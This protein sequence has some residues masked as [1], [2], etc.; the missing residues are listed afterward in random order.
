M[1]AVSNTTPNYLRWISVVSV[2]IPVAVAILIFMPARLNAGEWVKF[3]PHLNAVI[4]SATAALLLLGLYFIK[5]KKVDHHRAVMLG[6][7]ALGAIFLVSYIIYHASVPSVKYGDTNA[8]GLLSEAEMAATGNGRTVYLI[9]LLSHIGL[10][11]VVVPFVLMALYFALTGQIEKHKKAVKFGYP[12]W[13]YVSVT[14]V[15]VY[16]MIRPFYT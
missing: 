3:L 14:G 7:F 1:S 5:D 12:I 11:I 10:S 2:I 15:I 4:N 9:T 6:A 8:D 13:L 16:F